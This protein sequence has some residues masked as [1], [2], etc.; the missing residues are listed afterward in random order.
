MPMVYQPV[1]DGAE[2][3]AYLV[4]P[5][6]GG[7]PYA[8]P[9]TGNGGNNQGSGGSSYIPHINPET[10]GSLGGPMLS[11]ILQSYQ[12]QTPHEVPYASPNDGPIPNTNSGSG[13]GSTSSGG[14]GGGYYGGGSSGG[15]APTLNGQYNYHSNIEDVY[16]SVGD[17]YDQMRE[18]NEHYADLIDWNNMQ[19]DAATQNYVTQ[20]GNNLDAQLAEY[21]MLKARYAQAAMNATDNETMNQQILGNFGGTG[22]NQITHARADLDAKIMELDLSTAQARATANNLIAQANA[23]GDITKAQYALEIYST[24]LGNNIKFLQD[25]LNTNASLANAT[26]DWY[27]NRNSQL[28]QAAQEKIAAGIPVSAADFEVYGY[29]GADAERAAQYVNN[30]IALRVQS[31][32][33]ANDLQRANIARAYSYGSGGSS[34]GNASSDVASIVSALYQAY[35]SGATD[36]EIMGTLMMNG[37][38]EKV[39][40]YILDVY[41]QSAGGLGNTGSGAAG[42][43]MAGTGGALSGSINLGGGSTNSGST[44]SGGS[45]SSGNGWN[46]FWSGFFGNIGTDTTLPAGGVGFSG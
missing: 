11:E 28:M 44:P 26:D 3:R 19:V 2:D 32:E 9:N 12:G 27:F 34:S 1:D 33:L 16:N 8:P 39:A 40:E 42:G 7:G 36:S 25:E 5:S 13:G 14:G 10:G 18:H 35:G 45:G 20:L 29:T 17:Y 43:A 22:L 30:Q 4:N 21:D 41:K 37:Y 24:I 31:M 6:E 23:T 15:T 46:N 38:S